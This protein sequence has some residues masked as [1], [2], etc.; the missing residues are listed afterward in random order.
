MNLE[1]LGLDVSN[2][3]WW[4][5]VSAVGTIADILAKLIVAFTYYN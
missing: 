4:F 3:Y 1:E 2:P 5:T